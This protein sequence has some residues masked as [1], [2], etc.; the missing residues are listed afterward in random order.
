MTI[1]ETIKALRKGKKICQHGGHEYY[2]LDTHKEEIVGARKGHSEP[3]ISKASIAF[4]GKQICNDDSGYEI[5]DGCLLD[6]EEHN[7]LETVIFPFEKDVVSIT[8]LQADANLIRIRIRSRNDEDMF[9]HV[10]S[11]EW[12]RTMDEGK[13]YTLEELDL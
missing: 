9:L 8:K 3:I 10:L 12:F 1:E 7:Y 6:E 2:F 11:E 13:E 4:N 5:Y